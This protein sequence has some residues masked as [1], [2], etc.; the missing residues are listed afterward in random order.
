MDRLA[1]H[2]LQKV[3]KKAKIELSSTSQIEI[4]LPFIATDTFGAKHL[5]VTLIRSKFENLV[6]HLIERINTFCKNYLKDVGISTKD[7]DEL[8]LF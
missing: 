5:N 8:L 1:L 3:V 7:V 6:N 2:R 4:N